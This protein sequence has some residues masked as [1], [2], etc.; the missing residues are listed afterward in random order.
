ML[1][2]ALLVEA[3]AEAGDAGIEQEMI[4]EYDEEALSVPMERI[5]D[6]S[7]MGFL[8]QSF[9]LDVEQELVVVELEVEVDDIVVL[10]LDIGVLEDLDDDGTDFSMPLMVHHT[11]VWTSEVASV[12][13]SSGLNMEASFLLDWLFLCS[14]LQNEKKIW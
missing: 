13:D 4:E 2:L 5:L 10:D 12:S 1:V 6:C 7:N 14:S 11:W 3:F 8:E 9:A